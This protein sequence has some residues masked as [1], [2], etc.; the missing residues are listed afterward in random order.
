MVIII[1]ALYSYQRPILSTEEAVIQAY[2][3]LKNQPAEMEVNIEP[4]QIELNEVPLE[5]ISS[6]LH[7]REGFMN[8]LIKINNGNI[9]MS[10]LL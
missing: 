1:F 9:K 8:R 3:L 7:S 2:D 6:G 4:I 10:C 5:D